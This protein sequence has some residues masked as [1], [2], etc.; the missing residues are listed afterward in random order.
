LA[1]TLEELQVLITSETSG[2][3]RELNNVRQQLGETER[4]VNRATSAIGSAFK[5]LGVI[6]ASAFTVKKIIDFGKASLQTYND[7]TVQATKLG[8]VMRNTMGATDAQIESIKKLTQAQEGIGVIAWDTQ[9]AGAQ[10]LGTY[11]ENAKSLE[12]LIPTLND[13][14]AQQY[15]VDATAEQATN[16]GTMIGKVM[17]GQLGALSRYGYSWDEAQ[18]KVLKYGNELERANMLAEVIGQSVG[19]MNAELAKTPA[20]QLKQLEFTFSGIK[21]QIGAGLTPVIAT[22]LPYIQRLANWLA[23]LASYFSAFMQAFF[24]VSIAQNKATGAIGGASA[25]QDAYGKSAEKAGKKAKKAGEEARR[26]IAGFDEINSLTKNADSGADT[27]GVGGSGGIGASGVSINTNEIEGA[28]AKISKKVQ[29]F[30][31]KVKKF[32][33]PV[34][35]AWNRLKESALDFWNSPVMVQFREWYK[36]YWAQGIQGALLKVAGV[37]DILAGAIDIVNALLNGSWKKAWEGVGKILYGFWEIITGTIGPLFPGLTQKMKD[38]GDKFKAKWDALA[39]IN[40]A[41]LFIKL[42]KWLIELKNQSAQKWDEIKT[43]VINALEEMKTKISNIY[44]GIKNII[45]S[46]ANE[47]WVNFKTP[48]EG[49]NSWFKSMVFDKLANAATNFKTNLASI[50]GK[51]WE[52]LKSPFVGAYSWFKTNVIDKISN[53]F[54]SIKNAFDGS[55]SNGFKKVYNTA[56]GWLNSM[57]SSINNIKIPGVWDG[58]NIQK[59]PALAQGGYIGANSPMLA[60]IGDNRHEGEIVAPESKLYEQ[61]YKAISNALSQSGGSGGI[62]DLTINLGGTTVFR[63][64]IDGI[65]EVQRQAGKTLIEI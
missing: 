37:F 17:D 27:G 15:G 51:A 16:I 65:N 47:A 30:A 7:V 6:V 62:I 25:A 63:K 28:F 34:R 24:G 45:K 11:L 49:A 46:K 8:Q 57:I 4:E 26:S 20:G 12:T 19:G 54:S 18:E 50:A 60:M 13:M 36:A 43:K 64:L 31:N 21:E 5:K 61:T 2:L 1:T 39:N 58:V 53:A 38:F 35:D 23:T 33:I 22:V 42:T 41:E 55:I 32:M 40:Y 9:M 52:S 3:R 48:F 14:L 59:I 56:V 44:E 10:E 29:E